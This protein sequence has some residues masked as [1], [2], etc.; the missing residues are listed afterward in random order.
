MAIDPLIFTA[1]VTAPVATIVAKLL[2][3]MTHERPVSVTATNDAP[4][5]IATDAAMTVVP[6][7]T[8]TAPKWA[9]T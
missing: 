6:A 9:K 5:A 3:L 1:M 7:A 8:I 4:Q 2:A